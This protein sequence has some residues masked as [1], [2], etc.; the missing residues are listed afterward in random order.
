MFGILRNLVLFIA[1]LYY[2]LAMSGTPVDEG[3]Y[4]ILIR[5]MTSLPTEVLL[6]KGNSAEE[7]KDYDKALVIYM[8]VCNRFK[9]DMDEAG[10]EQIS[11]AYFRAGYMHYECGRY[12]KAMKFYLDGLKLC[13]STESKKYAAGFYKDI[14][15]IY[16]AYHDYERGMYYLKKGEE[17]LPACPDSLM[18]YKLCTSLFFNSLALNDKKQI[19]DSYRK[20]RSVKSKSTPLTRYME[21]YTS[22]LM[23]LQLE[24]FEDAAAKFLAAAQMA[25]RNEVGPL[26]ECSAYEWLY[27]TRWQQGKPDSAF[28]YMN[29]CRNLAE[30]R[31]ILHR[32]TITLRDLAE[33]Y[34]HKGDM[35]RSQQ[36]KAEYFTEMDS[37]FNTREFDIV[38][39]GL[40]EYEMEKVETEIRDLQEKEEKRTATIR[41]LGWIL[42][43]II[44][45]SAALVG[46]IVVIYRQKKNLDKSYR[47][48]FGMYNRLEENHERASVQYRECLD[49][50]ERKDRKR[51]DSS[52]LTDEKGLKLM[53]E[54]DRIKETTE[55]YCREDFTLDYLCSLVDSNTSYV[56]RIINSHYGKNFNSFI[57]EYRIRVACQRLSDRQYS[58][59]TIGAIGQSVGFRSNTTFTA[60]FRRVTG[61]TPSVYQKM[62]R[63]NRDD[64][65]PADCE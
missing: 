5:E 21:V 42:L 30:E 10:R 46:L 19:E 33:F 31:G 43:M 57:N 51:Y 49:M 27:K 20:L 18:R 41:R 25:D 32:F 17:A 65:N 1:L 36:Y 14:G 28:K 53:R 48:L 61:M 44:G 24:K 11:Y 29:I 6:E 56:S 58:R 59:Q 47:D 40:S 3:K 15:I 7:E 13:E 4:S 39:N 62:I 55:E 37:I 60:V 2:A 54:I 35:A 63:E 9:D 8:V 26:Y 52:S 16:N 50:L 12:S 34:E 22:G 64:D 38:K 45:V 23:D